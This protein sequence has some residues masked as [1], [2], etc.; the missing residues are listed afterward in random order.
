M[1]E[2]NRDNELSFW[3]GELPEDREDG[4]DE[5]KGEGPNSESLSNLSSQLEQEKDGRR[6]ERFVF[7][8]III[9][10][11][12]VMWLGSMENW[13]APLVIGAGEALLLFLAAKRW[14]LKEI[15]VI[16][17][18]WMSRFTSGDGS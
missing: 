11:L 18:N 17:D 5:G 13:T 9:L 15:V 6:E 8:L 16:I 12:D 2:D 1:P 3:F 14:G 10:L 7:F 4:S